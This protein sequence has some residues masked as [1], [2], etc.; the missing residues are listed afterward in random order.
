MHVEPAGQ[1][2]QLNGREECKATEES[3]LT[4]KC[5][6][7]PD[8]SKNKPKHETYLLSSLA[9]TINAP[10]KFHSVP[11]KML[12]WR[13]L[14]TKLFIELLSFLN[15][16]LFITIRRDFLYSLSWSAFWFCFIASSSKTTYVS[17][18]NHANWAGKPNI[19]EDLQYVNLRT[20]MTTMS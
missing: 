10:I 6:N 14:S 16:L 20:M 4:L 2:N 17:Y 5:S 19:S 15:P 11:L 7:Q 12:R 1:I 18:S 13:I 3:L 9:G 8:L